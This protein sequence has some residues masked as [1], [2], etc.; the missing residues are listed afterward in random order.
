MRPPRRHR[1]RRS[2]RRRDHSGGQRNRPSWRRP[3]RLRVRHGQH[4][5]PRRN[6]A[7]T[8]HR[9]GSDRLPTTAAPGPSRRLGQLTR[10]RGPCPGQQRSVRAPRSSGPSRSTGRASDDRD[11]GRAVCR[12]EQHRLDRLGSVAFR[13]DVAVDG[14]GRTTQRSRAVADG[15]HPR[16]GDRCTPDGAQ[17]RL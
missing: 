10:R 2:S 17:G 6:G 4:R 11:G 7:R 3:D 13:C 14:S 16:A 9:V 5:Q 15:R 12:A 8:G 1:R